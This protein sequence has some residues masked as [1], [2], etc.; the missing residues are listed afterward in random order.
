VGAVATTSPARPTPP[1]GRLTSSADIRAVVAARTAAGRDHVVV[2][3]RARS[4]PAAGLPGRVAVVAGRRVGGAVTRNRAKRR[5]RACIAAAGV[6]TGLDV[7]VS[8]KAGAD[9]VPGPVLQDEV[10]DALRRAVRRAIRGGSGDG[11]SQR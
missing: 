7:V 4:G 3:A 2:H 11:G 6:P 5:L 9:V 10:A 8:A 1:R